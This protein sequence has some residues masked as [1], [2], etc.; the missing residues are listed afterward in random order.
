MADLSKKMCVSDGAVLH[1]LLQ[2]NECSD[3]SESIFGS[4]NEINTRMLS[5]GEQNV[6]S[7]E[8]ENIGDSQQEHAA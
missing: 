2:E 1:E 5:Y 3:I 6:C 8:E 7:D 4:D